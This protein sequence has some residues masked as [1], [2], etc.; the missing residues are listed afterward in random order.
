MKHDLCFEKLDAIP[1]AIVVADLA[2]REV[3]FFNEAAEKLWLKDAK[4]IVG[5]AQS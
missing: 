5:H 1:I 3:L 2:S 4:E